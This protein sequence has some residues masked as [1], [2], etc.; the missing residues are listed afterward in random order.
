MLNLNEYNESLYKALDKKNR[1][2]SMIENYGRY[3]MH[4]EEAAKLKKNEKIRNAE[5]EA[6]RQ[7]SEAYKLLTRK[8]M[9]IENNSDPSAIYD[10]C[11]SKIFELAKMIRKANAL[12]IGDSYI[13]Q[14]NKY[15]TELESKAEEA[16]DAR[17]RNN[18]TQASHGSAKHSAEN[19]KVLKHGTETKNH[20]YF[21]VSADDVEKIRSKR[22][23]EEANK[24]ERNQDGNK[25]A[26]N[27]VETKKET[28]PIKDKAQNTAEVNA[29]KEEATP[30]A[31]KSLAHSS[32]SISDEE[33]EA[34]LAHKNN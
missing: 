21:H 4:S 19:G 28:A 20:S 22:P 32:F 27:A 29:K 10:A 15:R 8:D 11:R 24:T 6:R 13:S 34:F 2:K 25:V 26:A 16:R 31:A 1:R 17:S 7:V 14:L 9:Q 12:G 30:A 33:M 5:S 23:Q 3:L 18:Y